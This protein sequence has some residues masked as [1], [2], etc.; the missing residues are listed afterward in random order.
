MDEDGNVEVTAPSLEA[1]QMA[2]DFITLIVEDPPPGKIFRCA[3][4]GRW[5]LCGGVWE[6][7]GG[8]GGG[9]GGGF[10]GSGWCVYE[11]R[12][13]HHHLTVELGPGRDYSP[14]PLFVLQGP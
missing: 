2:A 1:A 8:T 5:G 13:V 6:G 11:C 9:G 3:A 7:G 4:G 12:S 14:P 10:N